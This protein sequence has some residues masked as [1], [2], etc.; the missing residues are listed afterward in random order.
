[1]RKGVGAVWDVILLVLAPP[2]LQAPGQVMKSEGCWSMGGTETYFPGCPRRRW[3]Q[4]HSEFCEVWLNKPLTSA[5]GLRW[6]EL[7]RWCPLWIWPPLAH[8]FSRQ[9]LQLWLCSLSA[10]LLSWPAHC[11][12]FLIVVAA[13]PSLGYRGRHPVAPHPDPVGI[14]LVYREKRREGEL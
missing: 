11:E 12:P 9:D 10:D 4:P 14:I 13:P 8:T 7:P 5:A 2:L 6:H 3:M 1:M